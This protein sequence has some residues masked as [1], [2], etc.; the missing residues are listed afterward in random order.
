MKAVSVSISFTT[1]NIL[2]SLPFV[3]IVPIPGQPPRLNNITFSFPSTV[4]IHTPPQPPL[5]ILSNLLPFMIAQNTMS[6]LSSS[7]VPPTSPIA[8]SKKNKLISLSCLPEDEAHP[9]RTHSP[10]NNN[11]NDNNDDDASI[12]MHDVLLGRG[13]QTNNHLGNR[14]YR[15]IV[16]E[17]QN[18]YL[19]AKK[20]EKALIARQIVKIVHTNGGRFLKKDD[21]SSYDGGDAWVEVPYAKAV[22]KTSQALREGLDVRNMTIRPNKIFR[23]TQ[24]LD[25]DELSKKVAGKVVSNATTHHGNYNH[26]QSPYSSLSVVSVDNLDAHSLP[27][28]HDEGRGLH[29]GAATVSTITPRVLHYRPDLSQ[30]ALD[31]VC[32]V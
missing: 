5:S 8:P 32:E 21:H 26:H 10:V 3:A 14:E 2:D 27:E 24:E 16:F 4:G 30:S 11:A 19:H 9:K 23:C 13:G 29:K 25:L 18:E 7:T 22:S 1:S 31:D 17:H 12:S 15:R 28:L 20:K 6:L